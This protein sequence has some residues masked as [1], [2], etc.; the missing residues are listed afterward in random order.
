MSL[1]RF[2][3]KWG[4]AMDGQRTDRLGIDHDL[5]AMLHEASARYWLEHSDPTRAEHERALAR[6]DLAEAE[7]ARDR[8][9]REAAGP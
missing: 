2:E 3:K 9:V 6:R 4:M 7:L 5:A 1:P 8:F